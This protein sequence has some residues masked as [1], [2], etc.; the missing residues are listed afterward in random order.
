MGK[1]KNRIPGPHLL[2]SSLA[3]SALRMHVKSLSKLCN[4][5]SV[6]EAL[7]GKLDIKI[8]S[9]SILYVATRG[10]KKNTTNIP[11]VLSTC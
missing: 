11:D 7:H 1:L 5:T 4:S 2:I 6:L 10:I 9:P 8:H 3:G